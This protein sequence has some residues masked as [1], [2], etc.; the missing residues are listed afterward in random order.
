M[1]GDGLHV[2]DLCRAGSGGQGISNQINLVSICSEADP[3][4]FKTSVYVS[5]GHRNLKSSALFFNHSLYSILFPLFLRIS[6]S[7]HLQKQPTAAQYFH[8]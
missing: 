8:T 7:H 5:L 3:L 4:A 6:K 1:L 2:V